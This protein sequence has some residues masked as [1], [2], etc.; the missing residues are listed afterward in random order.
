MNNTSGKSVSV[1]GYYVV[2]IISRIPIVQVHRQFVF[3]SQ[4]KMMRKYF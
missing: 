3:L 4:G 2:K 1:F